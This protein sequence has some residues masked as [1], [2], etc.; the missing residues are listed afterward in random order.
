MGKNTFNNLSFTLK[1]LLPILVVLLFS[2]ATGGHFLN[3]FVKKQMTASYLDSVDTLSL[4]LQEGVKDSLERGQMKNFKKLLSSQKKIKG[5]IDVS[6]YDR[7]GEINLSSSDPGSVPTQLS[8][9]RLNSFNSSHNPVRLIQEDSILIYTP[10]VVSRDCI[11]CHP[12]WNLGEQGGII[13]LA[14]DLSELNNALS[15]QRFMLIGG[16]T[17]LLIFVIL[18]III[19]A[20]SITRPVVSM[21]KAMEKLA[22]GNLDVIVPAQDRTDEIGKMAKAVKIFQQNAVEKKQMTEE[23]E[24]AKIRTAKAQKELLEKMAGSFESSIGQVID[25]VSTAASEL[26]SSARMMN[27]SA[28][29]THHQA[30]SAAAASEQTSANVLSVASATEELTASVGE[31]TQQVTA[32]SEIAK[33]AVK[34]AEKTNAMVQS[35][36]IASQKIGD[37]VQLITDIAKQ[38]NLL[39]LNATIEAARAGEV[40]KGFAVVANEVKELA[41]QTTAATTEIAE[42]INGIQDATNDAVSAINGITDTI[43]TM[44]EISMAIASAVEEQSAVTSDI[45]RNTN[46]AAAGTQELSK[47]ITIVTQAA[48]ATGQS[49]GK[50]LKNSDELSKQAEVL[51]NEV[52]IFLSQ[53]RSS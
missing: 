14:Y 49:A 1:I 22:G 36:T 53:V 41:K 6:L 46:Q 25:A 26:Q 27:D 12:T 44:N 11:R 38:T 29:Q 9:E 2:L 39:A 3:N 45:A 43:N 7:Q 42:H 13:T 52:E 31:I 8:A 18:F 20:K 17:A 37:V 50:V 40:G 33:E 24:A 23:Q 5:V 15:K 51:Q 4:S 30:A 48:D 28:D 35:L 47:S 16:I 34:K 10:Q 21:T 19:I 32:S